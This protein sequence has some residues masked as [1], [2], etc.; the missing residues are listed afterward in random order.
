MDVMVEAHYGCHMCCHLCTSNRTG[1]E[2]NCSLNIGLLANKFVLDWEKPSDF[3]D[4]L[5]V[6][7]VTQN[8]QT[9]QLSPLHTWS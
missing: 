9:S 4:N 2:D 7:G 5:G 3:L 8:S 1:T 6:L